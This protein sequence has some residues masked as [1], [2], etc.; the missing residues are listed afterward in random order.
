[1]DTHRYSAAERLERLPISG[2]HRVIFIII[3]LAFFF[4][5]MDLAMMTFLLGSI[6]VEFGLSTAQAGLLASSSFFG[7]VV[8]ASL[9]GMLADRFGRKPVFQWSIV[10]WGV[11]SYLCST[12]QDI[13][14]LTLFRILLGIGMGMEFPIAQSMLS[15][16]I[17]A[18]QRGRYIALM[19]GFWPLGF[20]AA[21]ALS[22]FLLPVIGW[23]D[24][25][26]VLAVPAVFVL[27]IR[28]FIPESPRWLEQAGRDGEADAVL[29]RI[30]DKVR[31]SLGSQALPEPIR[32][33]RQVDA[34]GTFFS[35]LT[36]IWSPLYRQRTMM[37]WSVWFFALLGFYGLTSWLSALL[38]QSGF[39]VTQSVYYTVLISLG[40][41]PGFLMAA[42]LVERWGRKPVCVMTLL[43][44]GVM[45]F[46]YGQ[47]AVFGGNVGLL[48]GTGLLMQFFL[49]GM[50]A[51]LYTYTPELYP[52]SAR[53]TGSG[54]AS[55]VGRIGSLLGPLVTGLVFPITGQGG[56]FALGALC[57]AVAAGVVWLFGMETRG[58]TLEEL[59]EATR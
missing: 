30:E 51:V 15:E 17:P 55:A 12:A 20:V 57:F 28:F 24:I 16:L 22:Y 25:F 29:G 13:E 7:M 37:I 53:A 42:W 11:A 4:D 19:D 58:R 43:G 45:A 54:F 27:V 59:S 6:K 49:F 36:R 33:P 3:A 48:I 10:L 56:V 18:R 14:T 50:W 32:L 52:T 21:G 44:G 34:P 35:A 47:S 40:G 2:Y 9:S 39:A 1:M 41:I 5:S 23:R 31:R 26:L 8:G 46:L 38:Q